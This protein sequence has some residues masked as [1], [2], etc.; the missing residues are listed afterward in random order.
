MKQTEVGDAI[1]EW[2][3]CFFKDYD[4]HSP[5]VV[6]K[7]KA[8]LA[9]CFLLTNTVEPLIPQ[10]IEEIKACI[11]EILPK[12]KDV[13][14]F[15]LEYKRKEMH[16]LLDQLENELFSEANRIND[17][18]AAKYEELQKELLAINA[19]R[20]AH[21]IQLFKRLDVVKIRIQELVAQLKGI[22][23]GMHQVERTMATEEQVL[24][25][26]LNK[27]ENVINKV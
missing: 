8:A 24:D 4:P 14:A 9:L 11:K 17:D 18:I 13:N 2:E 10:F 27:C 1:K 23:Q 12:D 16:F 22:T 21:S 25:A 15:I 3:S 7:E 5:L 20:E 26:T 6:E 19:E